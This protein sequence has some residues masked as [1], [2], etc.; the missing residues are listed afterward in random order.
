MTLQHKTSEGQACTNS[1]IASKREGSSA[2][3]SE[4]DYSTVG[5]KQ[6][7]G[8]HCGSADCDP[9]IELCHLLPG[10]VIVSS[11]TDNCNLQEFL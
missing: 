6:V 1:L 3:N 7:R 8:L 10:Q 5:G 2:P 11:V 4:Q 9:G